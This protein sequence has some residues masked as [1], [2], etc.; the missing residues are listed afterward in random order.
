MC[1]NMMKSTKILLVGDDT[2]EMYVKAF[3]QRFLELGYENVSLFATNHYLQANSKIGRLII[4][5]ENNIA[6]GPR[7]SALNSR[8]IKYTEEI[9]PELIF[10]YSSRLVYA[11][12]IK[13]LKKNGITIFAYNNDDPFAAYFPKYFWRHFRG[14]LKYIDVGFAYRE[15][16]IEEY[17]DC[18]CNK[19]EILRSYYIKNR[20]Y[21]MPEARDK[22]PAVV[23]LGHYEDD[24]R[25]EYI[26][27]L[28]KAKIK[29]GVPVRSWEEFE[30]NNPYLIKLENSHERYN[31]ILNGTQIAIVFLSKINNDTYTRRCFEIPVTKTLMITTYTDDIASMFKEDKEAVFFRNG[32]EFVEKIKYYLDHADE[33]QKIAEAGYQRLMK[34]GHEVA[35]RLNFIMKIYGDLNEEHKKYG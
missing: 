29:I 5:I 1:D 11:T 3:Y 34:D 18:G 26:R 24:E 10:L 31:E 32:E 6:F 12:T 21:Y 35:D 15:K 27:K 25:Q 2:Y 13:R 7:I 14:C 9:K 4:R 8:L 17:R 20:N 28:L 30:V 22:V 16:N 33:R 19:V 23:F